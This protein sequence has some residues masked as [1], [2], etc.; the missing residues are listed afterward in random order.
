M[1]RT[2]LLKLEIGDRVKDKHTGEK[3]TVD[4]I[5]VVDGKDALSLS[6]VTTDNC[7]ISFFP[8]D[9]IILR[10]KQPKTVGIEWFARGG[11]LACMGPFKTQ[12]K[13]WEA[14]MSAKDPTKPVEGATV[15]C[16]RKKSSNKKNV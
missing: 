9:L 15:W 5:F 1:N 12:L 10:K 14:V 11:G 7:N 8:R 4:T 6:E 3:G 16:A 2:Q 13:A